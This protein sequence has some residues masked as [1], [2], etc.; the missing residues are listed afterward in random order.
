MSAHI[1]ILILA[2]LNGGWMIFD[3]IH[4]IQKGKYFGPT[5]P[6]AWRLI[7]S[8]MGID[9]FSIGPF[10]IVLGLLWI[11]S[12]IALVSGLFWGYMALVLTAVATLWYI[13]IGTIISILT[14]SC[15]VF[16]K[17]NLG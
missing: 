9:P 6:G 12:S 16:F 10:F 3:G 5:T 17:S 15:L 8:K 7:V 13:K 1:T 11:I 2:A 14:L 4:V